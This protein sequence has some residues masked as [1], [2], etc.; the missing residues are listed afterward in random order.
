[1]G[2]RLNGI[3]GQPTDAHA[4]GGASL[5]GAVSDSIEINDTVGLTDVVQIASRHYEAGQHLWSARHYARLCA[6]REAERRTDAPV[7][8]IRHRAY[9]ASAVLSSVVF[10][11]SLVNE[12][13][14]DAADATEDQV[15]VRIAPLG[16]RCIALMG[17]YWEASDN[18]RL[19][20]LLSKFQMVLLFAEEPKFDRGVNPYQDASYLITI[21]NELVHFRP[22]WRT[23]GEENKLEQGLAGKFA[24]NAL[25]AGTG[26][27]WFP[28]KCLGAGCAQWSWRTGRSLADEWT[29]RLNIPRYYGDDSD[30]KNEWPK[31]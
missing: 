4:L 29:A 6:E 31:P 14:Q 12:V 11:E 23:Q 22:S 15:G 21:R 27:P 5:T 30:R 25:M 28:N 2:D 24:E 3:H 7:V 16:R 8:E 1:V 26:N 18:G 10:L 19:I 13:F 9:A 20:P 17:E